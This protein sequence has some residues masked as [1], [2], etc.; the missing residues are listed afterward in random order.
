MGRLTPEVGSKLG[1]SRSA[2]PFS[3]DLGW[4]CSFKRY[5]I[6]RSSTHSYESSPVAVA[7]TVQPVAGWL[8]PCHSIFRSSGGPNSCGK[9]ELYS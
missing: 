4:S 2:A 5:D 6:K 9:V 8:R 3:I 7:A 1:A